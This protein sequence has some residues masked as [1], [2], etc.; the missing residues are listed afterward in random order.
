MT[1]GSPSLWEGREE[2]AGRAERSVRRLYVDNRST[3][4]GRY[5]VRPSQREG[6]KCQ[7][8]TIRRETEEGRH[9]N[10]MAWPRVSIHRLTASRRRLLTR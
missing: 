8:G 7:P 10:T 1:P 4:P 9:P 5:R 3:L 6:E 2:R